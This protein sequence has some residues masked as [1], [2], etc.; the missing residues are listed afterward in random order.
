MKQSL[1]I[2]LIISLISFGGF[3]FFEPQL[4]EALDAST[5]VT[6]AVTGEITL[7]CSSTAALSP[8]IL[9]QTG[10]I[11]TGTFGCVVTTNNSSGYSLSIK[12]DQKLQIADI[13]NQRF[14][15]YTTN[16]TYADWTWDSPTAGNEEFGFAVN[17]CASTTDIIVNYRDNGSNACGGAGASVTAWRCWHNIPTTTAEAIG[18]RSTATPPGG[19]LT[20][21]GLRAEAGGSNSLMSGNYSCTTTVTATAP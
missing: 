2:T 7:S 18:S 12:K 15:D 16:T 6:L 14:D 20:T 1:S 3:I 19:I 9:G 10:G 5:N 8:A 13:V 11:A 17:S 21:F 4:V